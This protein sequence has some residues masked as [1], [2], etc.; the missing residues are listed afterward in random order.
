MTLQYEVKTRY[1]PAEVFDDADN[2]AEY[3]TSNEEYIDELE[4]DV[5]E[6]LNENYGSIEI[7]G[8]NYSASE[9]LYG[10]NEDDYSD[11]HREEQEYCA[12]NNADWVS[13]QIGRMCEGED[14][15]FE[16]G[17]VVTCIGIPDDDDDEEDGFDNE[18]FESA[19]K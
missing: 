12:E 15:R 6:S 8:R 14:L 10:L 4:V 3:I 9:I 11:A 5:D 7:R 18:G 17:I 19:L 1:G 2:A 13:D 16:G